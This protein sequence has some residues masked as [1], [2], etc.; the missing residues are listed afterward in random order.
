MARIK[1]TQ[2]EESVMIDIITKNSHNLNDAFYK[3]S[4]IINRTPKA[5][6]ERWYKKVS[7][8]TNY[9]FLTVGSKTAVSNRKNVTSAV[10]EKTTTSKWKRILKILFEKNI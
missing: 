4:E 2:E 1:W 9:C 6:S 3:A 7:K 8:E 10:V 5:I